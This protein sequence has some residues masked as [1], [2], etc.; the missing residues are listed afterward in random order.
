MDHD[1]SDTRLAHDEIAAGAEHPWRHS[2]FAGETERRGE[3]RRRPRL[4]EELRGS[5]QTE[6]RMAREGLF[7]KTADP[8]A[9]ERV[10]ESLHC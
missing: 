8:G 10:R 9:L 4:Y 6:G 3:L 1:A 7:V 5:S 2:S